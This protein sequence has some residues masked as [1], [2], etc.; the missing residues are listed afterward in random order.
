MPRKRPPIRDAFELGRAERGPKPTT[1]NDM[2]TTYKRFP[3]TPGIDEAVDRLDA[4]YAKA[5]R[6]DRK[7]RQLQRLVARERKGK[8]NA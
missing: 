5:E 2:G 6:K 4:G 7:A 8:S 3:P 1:P